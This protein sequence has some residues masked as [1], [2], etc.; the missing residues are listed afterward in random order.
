M[1]TIERNP[2]ALL[3]AADHESL[4]SLAAAFRRRGFDVVTGMDG[5]TGV[6]L[7]VDHLLS[8]DVLVADLD[9]PGRDGTSLL[10]LVRVAGGERDLAVVIRC[11]AVRRAAGDR[12]RALGA[13]ALVRASDG[14]DAIAAVAEEVVW[15]RVPGLAAAA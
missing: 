11:A 12:L 14:A 1:T 4:A 7:L 8:L 9:L 13:D 10:E 2:R 15:A 6:G 3:L 5:A